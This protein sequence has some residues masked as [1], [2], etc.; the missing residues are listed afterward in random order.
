[1]KFSFNAVVQVLGTVAQGANSFGGY[2]P[3]RYQVPFALGVGALQAVTALLAHFSN[4]NGTPAATP[5]QKAA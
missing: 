5:Y 4:P 3:P 1:M 2:V